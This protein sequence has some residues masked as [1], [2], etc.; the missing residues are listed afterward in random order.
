MP[1]LV[2]GGKYIFGWSKVG[3][4]GKLII[5][6]EAYLEYRL[7]EDDKGILMSGSK[8]SG[9]FGLSSSRLLKNSPIGKMLEGFPELLNHQLEEGKLFKIK[10][11]NYCWITIYKSGI[12]E[13]PQKT[14]R[15]FNIKLNDNLLVGRGSG[16]ALGFI[17]KG[18]IYEEAK[19]HSEIPYF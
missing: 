3:E 1:Q 12:I 8:R 11:K 14:L 10:E 2:K 4:N 13:I 9:G 7:N 19:N 15:A 18:P 17:A 6:E 16:L 5:P